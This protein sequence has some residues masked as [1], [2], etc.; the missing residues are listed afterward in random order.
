MEKI[1]EL[2]FELRKIQRKIEL[3]EKL[4]EEILEQIYIK[5][6]EIINEQL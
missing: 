5:Y 1:E 6:K 4:S 2:A 3:V